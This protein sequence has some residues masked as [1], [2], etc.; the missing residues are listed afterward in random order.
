MDNFGGVMRNFLLMLALVLT[1]CASGY[2]KSN[3][4]GG[5]WSK[6]GPGELIEVGFNGNGYTDIRK[7]EIYVLFRSA[8]IAK[9]RGKPYFSL[10]H[11]LGSAILDQPLS[12]ESQASDIGGKPYAKA[13]MLL[14]DTPVNGALVTDEILAKYDAQVKGNQAS[15]ATGAAQ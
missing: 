4:F 10:Y 3:I 1:G 2:G 5:Y 9:Q 8:E 11:D 7:V 14:H 13:F 6:D 12:V 15:G